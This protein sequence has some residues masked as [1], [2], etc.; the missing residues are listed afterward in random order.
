[1]DTRKLLLP[2]AALAGGVLLGRIIGFKGLV[3]VGMAALTVAKM[4][5][6]TGL[7]AA[8]KREGSRKALQRPARKRPA[9]RRSAPKKSASA[10]SATT[11]H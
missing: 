7:L 9:Q 1:M 4:S 2:A 5:E 8:G 11:T 6:T 3:R 10:N